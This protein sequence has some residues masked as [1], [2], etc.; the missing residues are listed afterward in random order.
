[1]DIL[2]IAVNQHALM[3]LWFDSRANKLSMFPNLADLESSH[4]VHV[5]YPNRI[6]LPEG[7]CHVLSYSDTNTDIH[8]PAFAISRHKS[9]SNL[10][11]VSWT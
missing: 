11:I 9:R 3:R 6:A 10:R 7:T 2:K 5:L 8:F 4:H 1:M